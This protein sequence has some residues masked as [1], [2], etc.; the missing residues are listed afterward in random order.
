MSPP[1]R[2][3]TTANYSRLSNPQA[4]ACQTLPPSTS[5]YGSPS[6]SLAAIYASN[7]I[8]LFPTHQP[9]EP[10]LVLPQHHTQSK[11]FSS[12]Q[13]QSPN[14]ESTY[15]SF[16]TQN[17]QNKLASTH[18][19]TVLLWDTSGQSL[20]PIMARLSVGYYSSMYKNDTK[21]QTTG[22]TSTTAT[23]SSSSSSSKSTAT[24]P[25]SS[26]GGAISP[27]GSSFIA[28]DWNKHN[29]T[30]HASFENTISTW[31]IRVDTRS[32]INGDSHLRPTFNII[33]GG[34]GSSSSSSSS[35]S[36]RGNHSKHL[37]PST[38]VSLTSSFHHE[39]EIACID[40]MG[41]VRIY[42]QRMNSSSNHG[43]SS[44]NSNTKEICH[45]WAH[46][47]G[48]FGIASISGEL[49][50]ASKSNEP[51]YGYITWGLE[52][53]ETRNNGND[54][55]PR[56]SNTTPTNPSSISFVNSIK[57]WK[58]GDSDQE[59][60]WVMDNHDTTTTDND[61]TV[62]TIYKCCAIQP[63]DNLATV[64]I[65][66]QPFEGGIITTST[67]TAN[68]E[69]TGNCQ[70]DLWKIGFQSFDIITSFCGADDTMADVLGDNFSNRPLI[71]S[72]LT[73]G[74]SLTRPMTSHQDIELSICCL[75]DAGFVTTYAIPEATVLRRDIMNGGS[76]GR[77]SRENSFHRGSSQHL[78]LSKS[79]D[80]LVSNNNYNHNSNNNNK[81]VGRAR[82]LS[83]LGPNLNSVNANLSYANFEF[84]DE[85]GE[86]EN[87]KDSIQGEGYLR[88][89]LD[90]D[91]L[92]QD[93]FG[94][95]DRSDTS[96]QKLGSINMNQNRRL[97]ANQ[98]LDMNGKDEIG[99]TDEEIKVDPAKA[100]RVPSPRLCGAIFGHQGGLITFHNGEVKKM[101][102]WYSES[103]SPESNMV[104]FEA[105]G[106]NNSDNF[107]ALQFFQPDQLEIL[108][109]SNVNEI[110]GFPRNLFELIQMKD[111]A[112]LAQWGSEDEDNE[113]D[114]EEDSFYSSDDS[115]DSVADIFGLIDLP[116]YRK[117]TG[118]T[119][120]RSDSIFGP[121]TESLVPV[122]SFTSQYDAL[123]MNG[124]R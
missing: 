89:Q 29:D 75:N 57:L 91:Q 72:E 43:S 10:L 118:N 36:S 122:V 124:Q 49:D 25:N 97:D 47:N 73:L 17:Q 51:M 96:N 21:I 33:V 24:T 120:P 111:K 108:S 90:D 54:N 59:N 20:Q 35:I 83:D 87:I 40:A 60:Y 109:V 32:N 5:H 9:Y 92:Y 1:P 86:I 15:L 16:S 117:P 70:V 45:F 112:I 55:S 114:I 101:W 106:V 74:S 78:P 58:E 116:E 28:L 94:L 76:D 100:K 93:D 8:V 107:N 81:K 121:T 22:S 84:I 4:L 63:I 18:A 103:R 113:N 68:S 26:T 19:N 66:P 67:P 7:G 88:L 98:E 37:H 3:R 6:S 102:K 110:G 42:D 123:I 61:T 115:G 99:E 82:G 23:S 30:I 11:S 71:A 50:D 62:S 34:G 27:I 46:Q 48:G 79:H 52:K 95:D 77:L 80:D 119:R 31:D 56:I 105:K 38:V 65:C 41:N 2:L 13:P 104:S 12:Q 64:R 69:T 85:N 14:I 39:Y 53:V 44:D